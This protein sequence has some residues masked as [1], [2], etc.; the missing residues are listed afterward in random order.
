[1]SVSGDIVRSYRAPRK[2]MRGLLAQGEREDRALAYLMVACGLIFVA[3]WPRLAR[4]AHLDDTVPLQALLGGALMGWLFIAPLLFYGLA[5]VAHL[6]LR[7]LRLRS[8]PFAARLATFWALLAVSPLFLLL[9]LSAGL[10]GAEAA[11]GAVGGMLL[12]AYLVIWIAGLR[13]AALEPA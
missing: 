3:Q 2:V 5:F 12:V 10:A 13:E 8:T 4:E 11:T 7:A 9:G 1:M 6:V